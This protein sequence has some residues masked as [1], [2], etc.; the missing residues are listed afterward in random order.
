MTVVSFTLTC[1]S[2][3][4]I[5]TGT[6]PC[7]DAHHVSLQTAPG[8]VWFSPYA[9]VQITANKRNCSTYLAAFH[10][11]IYSRTTSGKFLGLCSDNQEREA[12]KAPTVL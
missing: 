12:S 2:S 4:L 5:V 11:V 10:S 6:D 3:H 1:F 7:G 8:T 9:S